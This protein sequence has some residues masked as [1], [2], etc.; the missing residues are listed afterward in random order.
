MTL[1]PGQPASREFGGPK[2][3]PL[4]M[5]HAVTDRWT[6]CTAGS[7]TILSKRPV[8][9]R[10]KKSEVFY[11]VATWACFSSRRLATTSS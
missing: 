11:E 4:T 7:E 9:S 3:I 6:R 8:A 1:A 5:W 2:Q 10:N